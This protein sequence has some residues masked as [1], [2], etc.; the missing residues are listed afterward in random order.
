MEQPIP[1]WILKKVGQERQKRGLE[2]LAADRLLY[3]A[4]PPRRTCDKCGCELPKG[5]ISIICSAC[6][7]QE[8]V[9]V[10]AAWE[11]QQAGA[12]DY[13][14]DKLRALVSRRRG[15][16]ET[17]RPPARYT[18]STFE[19]F[20]PKLQ[21]A[22][23]TLACKID[24]DSRG[25]LM[26]GPAGVGKTHLAAAIFHWHYVAWQPESH[27]APAARFLLENDLFARLRASYQ[28]GAKESEE[29]ILKDY[30]RCKILILDDLC[31]YEPADS[32]FRNRIYFELFNSIYNERAP[33]LVVTANIGLAEL[34]GAL[35]APIAD[36]LRDM[37]QVV[38]MAGKSQRGQAV[39]K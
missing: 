22:A 27:P 23:Y 15:A 13:E 35:G 36:R 8:R 2:P 18:C 33:V 31:K 24:S 32:K 29:S 9:I 7:E 34:V 37:C 26:I 11:R 38:E 39:T 3:A 6:I 25:L 21:P 12:K 30:Q 14:A 10:Q 1:D 4:F 17:W 5:R 28:T 19:S 16:V 20:N